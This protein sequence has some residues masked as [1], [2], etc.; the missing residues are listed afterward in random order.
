M[1]KSES[2]FSLEAYE[3]LEAKFR[4]FHTYSVN[5]ALH[6]I[7]TPLGI[8]GFLILLNQI[9]A[10]LTT[11]VSI[12]YVGSLYPILP[13]KTFFRTTVAS[14]V[15][16]AL[17]F[18]TT[19]WGALGA[20]IAMAASFVFQELAHIVTGELTYQSQYIAESNWMGQLVEHTYYLLPLV[21]DAIDHMHYS[22]LD[23]AVAHNRVLYTKLNQPQQVK[24]L[25]TINDWVLNQGPSSEHTTHWWYDKLEGEPKKAFERITKCE[26][27]LGMFKESFGSKAYAVDIVDAMNE[28]YVAS[29]KYGLNSD[30]VFYMAHV[31]GPWGLFPFASTYRCII[32]VNVNKQIRTSFPMLPASYTLSDGDAVGFDFN[33]EVHLI[34]DNKE[35]N[36]GFRISL[37]IHYTVYPK[38]L[39]PWGEL[40]KYLTTRYN[41]NAR[42]LFL[43]TIEPG[44]LTA[45]LSA[46]MVLGTTY[47]TERVETLMGISN[48]VYISFLIL[49]SLLIHPYIFLVATSFYHYIIYLGTFYNRRDIAFGTFKRDAVFYKTIAVSTLAYYYIKHFE[50]DVIS[51]ILL[52]V[53]YTIAISATKA[54]GID[55]T[56]FGSELGHCKPEYISAFPY[57]CIPHPMIVG[58]CIG[59]LGF[60]KL[61]GL[62]HEMP[63]LVPTH[64]ILYLLH[65][66]QEIFDFHRNRKLKAN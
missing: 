18:L 37:K 32:A 45:K 44:S 64:I 38:I 41:T 19:Q 62:R 47:L 25:K 31:D 42:A 23:F 34:S 51:I 46:L 15:I 8:M 61:A 1:A 53:G 28:I 22:F 6:V 55:K 3:T 2:Q 26:N 65:M 52:A 33:R 35:K 60:H 4:K 30:G 50:V 66:T 57:N 20:C 58:A 63:Y 49:A 59:L 12:A 14:A 5:I 56:Y 10:Y 54:L 16:M 24:D 36:T 29:P 48:L 11:A 17:S 39:K 27:L 43:A 13:K 7:T 9:S 21:M 40:L